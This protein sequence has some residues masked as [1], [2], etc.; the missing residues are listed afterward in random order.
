MN[1]KRKATDALASSRVELR[2]AED[3][4][5]GT[6]VGRAFITSALQHIANARAEID[7]TLRDLRGEGKVD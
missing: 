2:I 7:E 1:E 6:W 5:R 3:A 4:L